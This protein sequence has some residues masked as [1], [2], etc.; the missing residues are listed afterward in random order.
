VRFILVLLGVLAASGARAAE[1]CNYAGSGDYDAQIA[2]TTVARRSGGD[3]HVQVLWRLTARALVIFRIRYLVEEVSDWHDGVLQSVG[4]NV[5]YFVNGRIVKQQWDLFERQGMGFAAWR[6]QA[7]SARILAAEH[8]EL[9]R[10]WDPA[11]FGLPWV[12]Q[13]R[14]GHPERRPDLDL[15]PGEAP[16]DLTTPFAEA[17]YRVRREPP[18]AARVALF[19]PGNKKEPRPNVAVPAP[20][21]APGGARV[22]HVPL[23]DEKLGMAAE[24]TAAVTVAPDSTL[25]AIGFHLASGMYTAE[26]AIRLEG[27]AG[28]P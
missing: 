4:L 17:F 24:S 3:E 6:V 18:H 16:P 15:H 11:G 19:L 21:P 9:L 23:G 7:K 20:T 27:C 12:A 28:S 10:L 14:A 2:I 1:T 26:G 22:W 13:Y 25:Q 5:R 8:G